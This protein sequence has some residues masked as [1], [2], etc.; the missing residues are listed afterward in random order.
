MQQVMKTG[1]YWEKRQHVS[2]QFVVGKNPD[3]L[4]LNISSRKACVTAGGFH[5]LKPAT[6]HPHIRSVF[7]REKKS[8]GNRQ[9][10]VPL[11]R[12]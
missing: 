5:H 10:D 7:L 12:I 11:P 2:E 8:P 9:R 6:I 4:L 1:F 3:F